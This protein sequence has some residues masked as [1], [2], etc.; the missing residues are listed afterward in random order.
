M[1][2]LE[3]APPPRRALEYVFYVDVERGAEDPELRAA[4]E[5]ARL[6]TSMLKI[7]GSY[8]APRARVGASAP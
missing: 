7:L 3:F 4:F 6:H 2:K 8:P 1:V 5:A